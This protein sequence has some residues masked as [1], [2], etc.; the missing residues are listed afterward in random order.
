MRGHSYLPCD[1]EFGVIERMQ[2]RRDH[3][4]IFTEWNDMIRERFEVTAMEGQQMKD[5]K[6]TL[7]K[8]YKVNIKDWKITK[9]KVFKYNVQNKLKV[10]T[11]E[12]MNAM[13]EQKFHLL[14]R[15]FSKIVYP[16]DLLYT[17]PCAIN[18]KK[19]KDV[20]SLARYLLKEESRNHMRSL[21][22]ETPWVKTQTMRIEE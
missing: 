20:Q 1:R 16:A 22:K 15:S 18:S 5:F 21:I 10:M 13:Q 6:G 8:L 4:E 11:Y 2:K 12:D 14:K 19:V 17:G 3:I 9:Y 7:G